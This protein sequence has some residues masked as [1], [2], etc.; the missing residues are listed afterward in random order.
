[1]DGSLE[2]SIATVDGNT[3]ASFEL[4][5]EAIAYGDL[6]GDGAEDAMVYI[7]MSVEGYDDENWL[8][9]AVLNFH[10]Y[11]QFVDSEVDRLGAGAR[12]EELSIDENGLVTFKWMELTHQALVQMNYVLVDGKLVQV[13]Q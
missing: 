2:R 10:G 3:T 8:I 12:L 11:P 1:M 4:R 6:N 13:E 7:A 9:A 5:S